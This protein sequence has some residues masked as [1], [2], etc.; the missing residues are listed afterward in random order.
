MEICAMIAQIPGTRP[1]REY[2]GILLSC[3][4]MYRVEILCWCTTHQLLWRLNQL[5][6]TDEEGWEINEEGEEDI[7][8]SCLIGRLCTQK[9]FSRSLLKNIL[10]RLW[11]LG[12]T[13]WDLKIKKTIATAIFL[14]L[15]YNS[16]STLERILGKTPWVLNAGFLILER[17]K[18]I[19]EDWEAT[20]CSYITTGRVLNLPI[21]AITKSNMARLVGMTGEI[22]EIQ[23]AELLEYWHIKLKEFVLD[24]FCRK[25]CVNLSIQSRISY[26]AAR[27]RSPPSRDS[28]FRCVQ[29]SST[30]QPTYISTL[31][32]SSPV[33]LRRR[34]TKNS[35]RFS[36]G[37]QLALQLNIPS[38]HK[39]KEKG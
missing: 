37:M 12:E 16:N 29:T 30:W 35:L 39:Y 33:K 4:L 20:L 25:H 9:P 5:R 23:G 14:V 17:M 13:E 10:C 3:P 38:Y 7:G 15:S 24:I 28:M 31:W 27:I 6:V 18:G 1:L 8:K 22:I 36:L 21:K 32:L 26:G 19:P 2:S 11:N 34:F